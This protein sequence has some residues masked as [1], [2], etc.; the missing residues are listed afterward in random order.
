MESVDCFVDNKDQR[1]AVERAMKRFRDR[2]V[3]KLKQF[4]NKVIRIDL[5]DDCDDFKTGISAVSGTLIGFKTDC[6]DNNKPKATRY[7]V[8]LRDIKY[9][10]RSGRKIYGRNECSLHVDHIAR[11]RLV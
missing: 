8:M 9:I 11:Y 1:E 10:S 5:V 2:K 4:L 6:V 3:S 7:N